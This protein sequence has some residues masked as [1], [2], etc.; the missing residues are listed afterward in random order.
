MFHIGYVVARLVK[1][2]PG[3]GTCILAREYLGA[4]D[5]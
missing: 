3:L 4:V 5:V 2:S 1:N